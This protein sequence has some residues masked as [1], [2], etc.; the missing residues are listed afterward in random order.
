MMLVQWRQVDHYN[1]T[2]D[3]EMNPHS[4]VHGIFKNGAKTIQWKKDSIFNK[5][6][7]H[8]WGLSCRRMRIDPFYLFVQSSSL[9]GSRN[10]NK[11]T[12]TEIYRGESGEKPL[13]YGHRGKNPELNTNGLYCKIKT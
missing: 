5:W 1:R 9:S 3:P 11:T 4:Y 7:W 12:D 6:C 2:E 13:R 10:S 8:N